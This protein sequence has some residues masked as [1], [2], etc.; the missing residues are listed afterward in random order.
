MGEVSFHPFLNSQ[1]ITQ[2]GEIVSPKQPPSGPRSN[3][4]FIFEVF[5]L[6][7]KILK[8]HLDGDEER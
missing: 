1:E 7:K 5:F 8:F 4:F 2:V 6:I 3:F